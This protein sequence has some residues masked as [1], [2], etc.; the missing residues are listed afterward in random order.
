MEGMLQRVL[1]PEQEAWFKIKLK[2]TISK[3][4]FWKRGI[5]SV[6]KSFVWKL[7]LRH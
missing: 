6:N 5:V 1:Q 4:H 7:C 2:H 3:Y